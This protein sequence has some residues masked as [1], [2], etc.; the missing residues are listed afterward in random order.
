MKSEGLMHCLLCTVTPHYPRFPLQPHA[1]HSVEARGLMIS[2][3]GGERFERL[4][5]VALQIREVLFM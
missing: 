3:R 4:V 2:Q 5:R 1:D